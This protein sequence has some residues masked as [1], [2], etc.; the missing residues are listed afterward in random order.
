MHEPSAYRHLAFGFNRWKQKP[1]RIGT[2]GGEIYLRREKG[3]T[4][5]V[6]VFPDGC[7]VVDHR[8]RVELPSGGRQD[9][10][11]TLRLVREEI[12]GEQ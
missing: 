5:R 9:V 3:G 7:T 2:P 8:G 12:E 11:F 10:P 4:V 6:D 1:L